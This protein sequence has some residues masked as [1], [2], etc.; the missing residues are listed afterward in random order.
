MTY[1]IV[2]DRHSAKMAK[3][4]FPMFPLFV[5]Y[6]ERLGFRVILAS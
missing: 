3:N 5:I 4:K 2:V 1:D 6:A